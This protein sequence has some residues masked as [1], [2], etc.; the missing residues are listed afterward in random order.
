MQE[1]LTRKN[2]Y[3]TQFQGVSRSHTIE[4]LA[5][6][7]KDFPLE[8]YSYVIKYEEFNSKKDYDP[9]L[10][11]VIES[12]E[13][14]LNRYRLNKFI[15]DNLKKKNPEFRNQNGL[16]NFSPIRDWVQMLAYLQKEGGPDVVHNY[17][18][19]VLKTLAKKS[20][21]KKISMTS[22]I[23]ELRKQLTSGELDP[24]SYTKEYRHLRREVYRNP[25]PYW[26]KEYLRAKEF[27]IS[28]EESDQ[29]VEEFARHN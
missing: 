7:F 6:E 4:E 12:N 9:H 24:V 18:T 26:Q 8:D 19:A 10:H 13:K 20:F 17:P 5:K 3:T 23:D 29:E 27:V 22:A 25:D 15:I 1:V 2:K 21:T 14:N 11:F 28:R 16:F